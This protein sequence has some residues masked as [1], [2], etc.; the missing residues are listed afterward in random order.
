LYGAAWT[1]AAMVTGKRWL[2][3]TAA[4]SS[5][6]ALIS[7]WLVQDTAQYLFYAFALFLLAFRP[8]LVFVLGARRA[9]A[10]E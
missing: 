5:V 3:L 1:V 4:G 2:W 8:G 6:G 10:D 7:A 9:A